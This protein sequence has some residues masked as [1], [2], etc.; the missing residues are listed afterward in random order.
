MKSS[1]KGF[2]LIIFDCDGVLVDSEPI[3]NRAHA[4]ML[5]CR[6]FNAFPVQKCPGDDIARPIL[7]YTRAAN[8]REP[9]LKGLTTIVNSIYN[10]SRFE[11]VWL[12]N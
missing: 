10:G 9:Y 11:G 3:I 2:E 5:I 6:H 1:T 12:A 7:V 8:C 4:Q